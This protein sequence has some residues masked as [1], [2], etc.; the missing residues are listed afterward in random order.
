MHNISFD[1]DVVI[2]NGCYVLSVIICLCKEQEESIVERWS[3]SLVVQ[4][5]IDMNLFDSLV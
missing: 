3:C 2:V 5:M 1:G 4:T